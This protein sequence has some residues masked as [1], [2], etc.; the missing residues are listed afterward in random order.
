MRSI[1]DLLRRGPRTDKEAARFVRHV[2]KEA[3]K[4]SDK[5]SDIEKRQRAAGFAIAK[6]ARELWSIPVIPSAA[7][8]AIDQS[9]Y[10][11]EVDGHGGAINGQGSG[12]YQST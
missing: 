8:T 12:V 10:D 5:W 4:I 3:A 6:E 7:A 1:D 2:W 11:R 9:F